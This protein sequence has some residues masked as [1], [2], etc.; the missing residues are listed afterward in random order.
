MA[1]KVGSLALKSPW[2]KVFTLDQLKTRVSSRF[3]ST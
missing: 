3:G 1:L 2:G